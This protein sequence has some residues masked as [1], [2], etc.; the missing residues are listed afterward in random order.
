M[1]FNAMNWNDISYSGVSPYFWPLSTLKTTFYIKNIHKIHTGKR[2]I[3]S[4][5]F[6]LP[7]MINFI[8]FLLQFLFKTQKLLHV[9]QIEKHW[10]R[11]WMRIEKRRVPRTEPWSAPTF[12]TLIGVIC[13]KIFN[14]AWLKKIKWSEHVSFCY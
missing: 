4:C 13:T 6:I 9:T 14:N 2:C 8:L 11:V 1:L 7:C 10:L 5:N 12:R 3:I